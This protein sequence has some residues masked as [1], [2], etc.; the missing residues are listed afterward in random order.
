MLDVMLIGVLVFI[1]LIPT[2]MA[3]IIL[4]NSINKR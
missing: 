4:V 1:A 3:A 2:A